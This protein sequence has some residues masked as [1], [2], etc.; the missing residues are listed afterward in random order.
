MNRTLFSFLLLCSTLGA[1]GQEP[2]KEGIHQTLDT[3][4][5]AASE[6]DFDTY[7]DLLT[8]D[9]VFVGT[10][11]TEVWGK[12]AF[13]SF[14][15]PYFDRGKAWSFTA[16]QRNIYVDSGQN[17]AWFDELLDTWMLLCRGSGVLKKVNGEWKISHYVLSITI[18]NDEVNPVIALKKENDSTLL[19]TLIRR[20]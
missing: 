3:W 10:D 8:E 14:S 2:E 20:D 15:K 18:P 19:Q 13:M 9:A 1:V 7:F 5:R 16:V 4:H 17:I 6:A 11:A 12:A